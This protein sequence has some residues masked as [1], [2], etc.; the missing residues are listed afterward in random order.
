MASRLIKRWPG[1]TRRTN[2]NISSENAIAPFFVMY[3]VCV[4][5]RVQDGLKHFEREISER[6]R[7][8]KK[9]AAGL[10]HA[11]QTCTLPII[12]AA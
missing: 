6:S 1:K 9:C 7:G 4:E 5:A 10:E 12:L 2:A 11:L 8:G 3:R